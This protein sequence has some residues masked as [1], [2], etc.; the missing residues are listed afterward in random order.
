MPTLN[1]EMETTY[2]QSPADMAG[3]LPAL[4]EEGATIVGGCCGT[5]PAHIAAFR[6]VLDQP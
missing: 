3:A 2:S 6:E 5:E 1:K 4:L